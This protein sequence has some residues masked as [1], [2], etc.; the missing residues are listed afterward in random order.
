[1]LQLCARVTYSSQLPSA[2]VI[3]IFNN[4]A[5]SPLIR[6]IHSVINRSPK[7]HLHEILLVDDFSDRE[8]LGEKLELYIKYRLPPDLVRVVRLPH[9]HGLI[10]ARLAGAKAAT[11]DVLIF[12][13][14]HCE[15]NEKW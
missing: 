7:Q 12:L 14:S 11:G 6:T 9:R 2:S 8:E 3:I 1:M 13:D 5:W 4:E 15:A 10:R